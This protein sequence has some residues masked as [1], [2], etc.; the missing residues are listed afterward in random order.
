MEF[1]S[2]HCGKAAMV[3]RRS[4]LGGTAG[5]LAAAMPKAAEGVESISASPVRQRDIVLVPPRLGI[6]TYTLH[7]TLSAKDPM[8][9][10]DIWWVVEQLDELGVTGLQIDPSHF[11]G[12]EPMVLERLMTAMRPRDRYIEFG[13]GGW[14]VDRLTERIKLTARFGGKALRTFCGDEQSTPEQIQFFLDAAPPAL[15]EAG[16]VAEAYGVDIAIENHGDFTTAEMRT[17][18]ERTN[19]PRVG[20]CFDTGNA[21]FRDEDPLASAEVLLPIATSMHLKDWNMARGPGGKHKWTEAVLGEGQVPIRDILARAVRT[22][23]GL[24]IALETPVWPGDDE[25]ETVARE[26]RHARACAK[27]ARRML[28]ELGVSHVKP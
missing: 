13:M 24:Y 8:L 27:A 4:F 6:D 15:R 14:G 1:K 20:V 7:R 3:S 9:R 25:G 5:L 19:H 26:W 28:W 17:L 2:D 12:Q 11:P 23:P 10:K 22:R 21:L 16:E 18:I